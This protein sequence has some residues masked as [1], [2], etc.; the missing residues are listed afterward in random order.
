MTQYVFFHMSCFARL[1]FAVIVTAF[2]GSV[3]QVNKNL[4]LLG[5]FGLEDMTLTVGDRIEILCIIA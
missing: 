1:V 3:V 5:L 4:Y 2:A